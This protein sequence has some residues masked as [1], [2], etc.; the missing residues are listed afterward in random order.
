MSDDARTQ[1]RRIQ[2]LPVKTLLVTVVAGPDAGVVARARDDALTIGSAEGNDLRLADPHVSRFHVELRREGARIVVIDCGSTNGSEIAT[3]S[4]RASHATVAPGTTV[5]IGETT[6]RV[7]DGDVVM[8]EAG[9]PDGLEELRG[10]SPA[11][12]RLYAQIVRVAQGKTPALL[13]GESGTGKELIARAIHRQW[14]PDRPFVT[15]DCAATVPSLFASELFG[16][17]RGAF[18][19]ADQQRDGAFAHAHGGTIFL[20]E[21]GEVP[22][23]LQST[24]LGVLERRR[25][26]KLGGRAEQPVD[27]RVVS[28]TNRDLR[29][30]VNAGRFRADLYY[31]LAVV[32]LFV[33][34][35][36][37]RIE[38]LPVLVDHLLREAGHDAPSSAVFSPEA[39]RELARHSWPGNVRELRNVVEASLVMGTFGLPLDAGAPPARVEGASSPSPVD[40]LTYKEARRRVLDDFEKEYLQALLVRT[41]GN[42]R[43]A[44]RVAQMDRK[45]LM[46]LL[47][48]HDLP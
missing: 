4:I 26:R 30:E 41:G 42:V 16:H 40:G 14:A 27:V 12:R 48:D 10:R 5:R 34:P 29:G 18:T 46:K 15:V 1:P 39:M 22:L 32:T 2:G 11:M 28:A 7:D 33:P 37:E 44:A 23:D 38:D 19:G 47:R 20:D 25:F 3:A 36:R 6:L 31:R 8:V 24:L 9:G 43:E 13:V 35:L 17:E 45:Y 21:I